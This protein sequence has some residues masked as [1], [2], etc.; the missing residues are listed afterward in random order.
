MLR[1]RQGQQQPKFSRRGEKAP[2]PEHLST[3]AC[4]RAGN[5]AVG[6]M[7]RAS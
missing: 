7:R 3:W 5:I 2:A 6:M 4:A 1:I